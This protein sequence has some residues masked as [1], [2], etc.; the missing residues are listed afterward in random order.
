MT[1]AA[2]AG[3]YRVVRLVGCSHA[4]STPEHEVPTSAQNVCETLGDK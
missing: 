4:R 3:Y 1:Y 2:R